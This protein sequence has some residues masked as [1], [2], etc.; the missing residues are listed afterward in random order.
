MN[1]RTQANEHQ[2]AVSRMHQTPKFATLR[3]ILFQNRKVAAT[4]ER[5]DLARPFERAGVLPTPANI[6]Q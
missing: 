6:E 5:D 3:F 4:L 2:L 1:K